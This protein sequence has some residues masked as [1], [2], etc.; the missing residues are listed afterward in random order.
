MQTRHQQQQDNARK[1]DNTKMRMAHGDCESKLP[2]AVRFLYFVGY[3]WDFLKLFAG[4][5][6][7]ANSKP[8]PESLVLFICSLDVSIDFRADPQPFSA[9]LSLNE[10]LTVPAS[11]GLR[12][13]IWG[14]HRV[15]QFAPSNCHRSSIRMGLFSQ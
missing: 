1:K 14:V 4:P 11:P 8:I 12:N 5:Q 7:S 2:V 9:A 6:E 3:H 15:V 13:V 10:G